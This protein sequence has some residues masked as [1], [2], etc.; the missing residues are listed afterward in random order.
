MKSIPVSIRILILIS[1]IG[2]VALIIIPRDD[3]GNPCGLINEGYLIVH[4][5]FLLIVLLP[6][7]LVIIESFRKK[8]NKNAFIGISL[9]LLLIVCFGF[10]LS[11]QMRLEPIWKRTETNMRQ[12][13]T[14]Q[15]LFYQFNNRYADTQDELVEAGILPRKLQDATTGKELTDLDNNGIEGGDSDANTWLTRVYMPG[16]RFEMCKVVETGWNFT[17]DQG[18]CR[19]DW[20]YICDQYGCK[21]KPNM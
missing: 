13:N 2:I 20:N 7:V 16:R 15:Q 8:L 17:C 1:L 5:I 14:A 6:C 4:L 12:L 19:T 3:F 18:G 21:T 10:F 9:I 11:W